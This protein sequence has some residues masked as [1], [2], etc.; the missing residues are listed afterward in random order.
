MVKRSKAERVASAGARV[1]GR[2]I[3]AALSSPFGLGA[4]GVGALLVGLFIFRD[5]IS[6]FFNRIPSQ[7]A[8]G[9]GDISINLPEINF[10]DISFPDISFPDINFP[11]INLPSGADLGL[12]NTQE[13]PTL[14][15]D[16]PVQTE[17]PLI[18]FEGGPQGPQ[19]PADKNLFQ[20]V[21]LDPLLKLLTPAE[22]FAQERQGP[23]APSGTLQL[24]DFLG[25]DFAPQEAAAQVATEQIINPDRI[26][27]NLIG[28]EQEFMGG[29]VGF[30][31][32]TIGPTP[33]TTLT[34]V[35]GLFPEIT[36]SQASD[37]LRE[38]RGIL[39]EAAL[40]QGFDVRNITESPLDPPQMFQQTSI[41]GLSGDP[42]EI[43]RFLFPNV[44]SNF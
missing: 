30:T 28:T 19:L 32:G 38:N 35:L 18:G 3:G 20:T 40:L 41:E 36:A 17:G 21:I 34:Q 24:I 23:P 4:L 1:G 43:F 7:I 33:I 44:I 31:F 10:P 14:A 37:F 25:L 16:A 42:N 5:R 39:P 2:G 9:L 26:V 6:E 29:G 15:P 12:P 27:A 22:R 13:L 11:E 8:G